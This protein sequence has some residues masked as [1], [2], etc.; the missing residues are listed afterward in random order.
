MI[1]STTKCPR[2]ISPWHSICAKS[3]C[4]A[5]CSPSV[6]YPASP[7]PCQALSTLLES[8]NS[9]HA[10][11][12]LLQQHSLHIPPPFSNQ[13][14]THPIIIPSQSTSHYQTHSANAPPLTRASLDHVS[15][16]TR[17]SLRNHQ[18]RGPIPGCTTND[19][20]GVTI[21]HLSSARMPLPQSLACW[22]CLTVFFAITS[23]PLAINNTAVAVCPL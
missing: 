13:C 16:H 2:P 22:K 3:P 1:D 6:S 9:P 4:F 15:S 8:A 11:P 23:T 20:P 17:F 21:N 10:T 5:K 7:S 14:Y 18:H 12:C 19:T